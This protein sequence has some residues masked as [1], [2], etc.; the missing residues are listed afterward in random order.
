[1]MAVHGG[2]FTLGREAP[3]IPGSG[4]GKLLIALL[5]VDLIVTC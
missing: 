5:G 1:M 2:P 4:G 3:I